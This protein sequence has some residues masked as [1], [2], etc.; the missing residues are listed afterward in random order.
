MLGGGQAC[1][2]K[3]SRHGNEARHQQDVQAENTDIQFDQ[4]A[5]GQ[6]ITNTALHNAGF[7]VQHVVRSGGNYP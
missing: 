2:L 7:A 3:L 1:L 6:H 5:V 4:T